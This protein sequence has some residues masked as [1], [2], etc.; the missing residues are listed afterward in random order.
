MLEHHRTAVRPTRSRRGAT[1]V[2]VA[3]AAALVAVVLPA[4]AQAATAPPP[5]RRIVSGWGYFNS[6]TSTAMTALAANAD[7]FS[8]VSPFWYTARWSGSGSYVAAAPYA[9]NKGT[10]LPAMRATG[11]KVLPTVTDGMPARRMAAVMANATT[12]A[13]F[14]AQIVAT[15][16]ANG[17]DGIDLDF[18]GFAFNDGS[19]TWSTTR[20]AWIAFVGALA[21]SLHANGKLLSVT[22]PAGT[23]TSSDSTGY[24]VYAWSQIGR[25]VDR[26]RVMAYDYSPARPGPIGPFPW[27]QK[28]VA[29]AVTQVP[30]GK[31]QIGVA[32]YGRDWPVSTSGTCPTLAPA[33][34][35]PAQSS[36]L[37]SSLS[38]A[39]DRHAFSSRSAAGYVG[40]LFV[41][42]AATVPGISVVQA[43]AVSWDATNKERTYPYQLGFAGRSQPATVTTTAVG[44][45]GAAGES[46]ITVAAP[47][48]IA[49]GATVSGSG[50]ATG[51]KVSSIS[52]NVV[53]LSAANAA[54][55]A[56]S[57]SFT[58]STNATGTPA[59]PTQ[60]I[61]VDS[62][63]GIAVGQTVTST[64]TGI[65]A[66]ATVVGVAGN[67]VTLSAALPA[68]ITA[69]PVVFT[70]TTATTAPGGVAG[71]TTVV[72]ASTAGVVQDG[73]VSGTGVGTGATVVSVS[74]NVVTL[75]K[76]NTQNVTGTLTVRPAPVSASCTISRVGWYSDGSAAAARAALVGQY[77]LA[78]IAQWTIGGEDLAQWSA[79]RSYARTIAPTPTRVT[80]AAPTVIPYGSRTMV[81]VTAL[82]AGV[83]AVGAPVT[84]FFRAVGARG[85][86]KIAQVTTGS[87]GSAYFNAL[88]S[89][90]GTFRAYVSGTYARAVGIAE[91][92][93]ALR[94]LVRVTAPTARVKPSTKVVVTLHLLP[95]H[96][97]QL[98][99]LQVLRSGR[100]STLGSRTTD[101][102]GRAFFVV[103][104]TGR[105]AKN[106]YRVVTGSW[107]GAVATKAWFSIYTR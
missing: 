49:P 22:V 76:P 87:T 102:W 5:P 21:A 93:V 41:N 59:S 92:A 94:T 2:A 66:G 38:W 105:N 90:K 60:T 4:P 1:A 55:V 68:P 25:Y 9:S 84:L 88:V 95:R 69:L 14:V 89:A 57:V 83:P 20:P 8:D 72:L 16:T 97:G 29:Q 42:Q 64:G 12:R 101:V 47:V 82:T 28:V 48:G 35:T 107:P 85:W 45:V 106:S 24:W 40:S 10:V 73:A 15:V 65:P 43:P 81:R 37:F 61:T 30:S 26:L 46:T 11:V 70:S 71:A 79:L 44:L 51:T 98:A 31:I 13:R 39:R 91:R 3:A 67:V 56:G 17:Y 86:T 19:S 27:V 54:I 63:A 74:G 52:G 78:G 36:S 7:L 100:W 33:G 77:Q 80:I 32:A 50:I 58:A 23:A 104:P 103:V 62:A 75:S 18:E 99:V 96:K 53:T 6:T 34:A